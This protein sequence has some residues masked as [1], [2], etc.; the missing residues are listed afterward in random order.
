MFSKDGK[1]YENVTLGK[2]PHGFA[3]QCV[4]ST[5]TIPLRTEYGKHI[6]CRVLD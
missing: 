2:R 4:V 6:Y 1:K 3:V 5:L